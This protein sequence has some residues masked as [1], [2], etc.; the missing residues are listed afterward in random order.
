MKL[1]IW[2]KSVISLAGLTAMFWSSAT[3]ACSSEPL[4]SSICTMALNPGVRFQ[5]MNNT[6]T[7][8]AGQ[9]LSLNSYA[10]L[11]SVIGVTYGGDGRTNFNLPDLRGK[12]IVGYD[13]RDAT[14]A[15]G[16]TGGNTKINLTVAQLPQHAVTMTN[17]PVNMAGVQVTTTLS[18]LTATA[19]LA[20]VVMTGPA[21]GLKIKASTSNGQ[22][23]PGGN[24]LG[25]SN[26]TPGNIYSSAATPD[27]ELN[28]GSIAGNLSMTVNA[29]VTAPVTVAGTAAS[30][31][32]GA[33]TASGISNTVGANADVPI[34]PP[35]IVMPY[36]IATTGI[37]PSSE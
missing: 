12:V 21:T 36:Y 24:F 18:G 30:T 23:T 15:V 20:G 25:K 9:A 14:R 5:S 16:S 2:S 27:A 17:M 26:G 32:S 33:A 3:Y 29:G 8:A 35:Y 31:L 34:M 28:A 22:M 10:A 6:Y 11:Y 19:N 7:L 1:K 4:V 13:P 37:Y